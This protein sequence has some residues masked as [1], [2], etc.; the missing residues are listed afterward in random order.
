MHSSISISTWNVNGINNSVLGNKLLNNDFLHN[1]KDHDFIFLTETWSVN[2]NSIPGFKAISTCTARP[3]SNSTC[4]ISGGIS[5]LLKTKFQSMV[6][7]EK[8]TKNFLWCRIDKSISNSQ[9]DLFLCGVYIPPIKSTYFDQEIF[10]NLEADILHYSQKGNVM[11]LGDFNAR[12]S[13]LED[14]ISHEG[15]TF[16]N[17]ITENS[18]IPVKRNN[19]DGTINQHGKWLIELCKTCN[20]RILNG[21]TLGDSLGRPTY[22]GKNGISLIDYAICDQDFTRSVENLVVKPPTYLSDHSQIVTWIK[23]T[24]LESSTA[25]TNT[26]TQNTLYKLPPQFIWENNSDTLFRENLRSLETQSKLNQLIN[27]PT[28]LSKE[29]INR[30]ASEFQNILLHAATKSLRIKKKKY[31]NKITNVCNKKWFDKECRLKR[32][33]VRKLANQKHRDPLN[34][35]LRNEYHNALKIY[36]D[37]LKHK[38]ELFHENKLKDLERASETDSNLFWKT[39]KNMSDNCDTSVSSSPNI[40]AQNWVS[41]FERLH[42]KH[43]I[44][45]EQQNI[46]QQLDLLKNNLNNSKLLDNPISESDIL[47]AAKKLKSR[48]SAYSDRIK[49]EMIKSSVEIL[50]HGYYKLFNLVLEYGSFPDQW[51][52]GL[53]TPIFKSGD[54]ND[55]NNYRGICVTSCLSKFF[56][57]ILNER[58]TNYVH[59]NNMVHPSQI[60]FQSGQ[61]TADHI[62]TLKTIFDKQMNTNRNDKVYAC[63][64]DFKKAFDSVW[65]EGL[66]FKLLENKIDGNFLSLIK[67]L[68]QTSKCAIKLSQSRTKF[69]SYSRGV[70]QGCILSPILFNLYI[71]ELAAI[72]DNVNSDPFILPNNT[73]LSCLL[74]A[75]DLIIL[76]KSRFGLQ[77]CLDELHNWCNKWLME[78]NLKKTKIMI[79]QKG[80][81]KMNKPNFTLNSKN[82]EI[83]NEYCYLGMKLM[84][85]GNFTLAQKQLSEKALHALGSIRRH[86]NLHHLN[87]KLA[88]KIFESI[89]SPILLYNSEVWGAYIKN[90]QKKWDNSTTEKTHLRFCKLYL[91]VGKKAS[92]MASRAELGKFPLQITI[93]KRLFKYITHINSL[94]ETAIAKQAFLISK[95]LYLNNKTCFYKNA[96]DILKHYKCQRQIV[97]LESISAQSLNPIIDS[98]KQSFV[99]LWKNQIEHS[100]KLYFYSTLKTEYELEKYL[101][102]IKNTNHRRTLTRFRI[103]NHKLMIECGR[104]HNIPHDERICKLCTSNEIENEEHL[105]FSCQAY[106]NIRQNILTGLPNNTHQGDRNL[107]VDL[108]KSTD[109]ETILKLSKFIYSCFELRD[110]SLETGNAER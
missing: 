1:V 42:A 110:K 86:L 10:E 71:N 102:V 41:H 48:K 91:G 58:L 64:V 57:I 18:F 106:D 16:I 49:N 51:C 88:I 21:R 38:K 90:D 52:E 6:T 69:F 82:V 60:G 56:C 67:S 14:F 7:V 59:E 11:L 27:S 105:L 24:Q 61:R 47:H 23:T 25:V 32:H 95:D 72:F 43:N 13:K 5:L 17:D 81:T 84:P 34:L 96:M 31:R 92:N 53:I 78:V 46:L 77:K 87:P 98:V 108:L 99:T 44:G 83:V 26:D 36:K 8:L 97:D 101:T 85:N 37:T 74:Y 65:H 30:F 100:S 80:N 93:Y 4:R 73:K 70:R 63:F 68:Y 62:F 79:F 12:T 35:E 45:T 94:P 109:D 66:F 33:K 22:H 39:L 29:G 9:K 75:D 107:S 15:N 54:N 103:S 28:P 2:T 3:K 89:V 104:Y 50:L 19:F 55:T 40:T 76:S 20:L